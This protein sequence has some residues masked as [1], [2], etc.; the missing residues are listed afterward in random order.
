MEAEGDD[1][2]GENGNESQDQ[3]VQV[4]TSN[5][6]ITI[7][8]P[9][10]CLLVLGGLAGLLIS[11]LLVHLYLGAV[12]PRYYISP[13]IMQDLGLDGV[14]MFRRH[15]RNSDGVLDIVEF[16]PLAHRLLEMNITHEYDLPLDKSEEI[17]T[18]SVHLTPFDMSTLSKETEARP[19]GLDPLYGLKRWRTPEKEKMNFAARHFKALLPND[20]SLFERVGE[21]YG[22][23]EIPEDLQYTAPISANR[24]VPP[25]LVDETDILIHKILTMVHRYPFVLGRF[26]PHGSVGVVRAFSK[27]ALDIYFRI[28]AEFQL[29]EPPFNPFWFTPGQFTGHLIIDRDLKHVH[30]FVIYVP[31]KT[32]LNVDMEWLTGNPD[33]QN[34]EVDIGYLPQLVINSTA[35]S[36]ILDVGKSS[37]LKEK[38]IEEVEYS[39][40]LEEWIQEISEEEALKKMEVAMYPFKELTYFNISDA[41]EIAQKESKLVHHILLW[42]AL[43]DQSC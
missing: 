14:I 18:L 20:P 12:R 31:T 30:K 15:D 2:T 24:Y 8:I 4:T 11:C 26:K 28:H 17:L 40:D 1:L 34:M 6:G 5:T 19:H 32:K 25:R 38:Y 7:T 27:N 22:L 42:G 16:E 10:W 39:E 41:F 35:P 36:Q 23:I 29:N 9:R 43:D 3:N 33:E 21:V 37:D 13:E